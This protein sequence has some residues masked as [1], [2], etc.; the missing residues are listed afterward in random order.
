[1]KSK[2]I[3]TKRGKSYMCYY[4]ATRNQPCLHTDISN[5]I[6]TWYFLIILLFYHRVCIYL[7]DCKLLCPKTKRKGFIFPPSHGIP[8]KCKK[9]LGD[10]RGAYCTYALVCGLWEFVGLVHTKF[11][12]GIWGGIFGQYCR[13]T[14]NIPPKWYFS[15]KFASFVAR[16]ARGLPILQIYYQF[17]T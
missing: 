4:R 5:F 13:V 8:P 2:S 6:E 15:E 1:M 14:G 11:A 10:V 12:S 3:G 16:E 7:I 9:R 17:Q